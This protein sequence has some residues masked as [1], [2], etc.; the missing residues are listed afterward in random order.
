[1]VNRVEAKNINVNENLLKKTSGQL[2][3]PGSRALDGMDGTK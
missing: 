2:R 3:N 1:M